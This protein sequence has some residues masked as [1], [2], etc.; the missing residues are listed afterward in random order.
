[1]Q[2]QLRQLGSTRT[3][4]ERNASPDMM[5][6][7]LCRVSSHFTRAIYNPAQT[8]CLIRTRLMYDV[9]IRNTKLPGTQH[10]TFRDWL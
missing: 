10:V 6:E 9:S 1:M 7:T 5:D 2:Q 3:T 8:R 4:I